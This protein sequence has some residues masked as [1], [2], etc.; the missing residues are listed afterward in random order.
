[1]SVGCIFGGVVCVVT[2]NSGGVGDGWVPGG[3][4]EVENSTQW[5]EASIGEL[6][7]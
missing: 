4:N 6:S 7:L 5:R 3:R 2:V 1:M